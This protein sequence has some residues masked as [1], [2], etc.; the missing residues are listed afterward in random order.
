MLIEWSFFIGVTAVKLFSISFCNC[1]KLLS[2][3]AWLSSKLSSSSSKAR[4]IQHAIADRSL[5]SSNH[6]FNAFL[7]FIRLTQSRFGWQEVMD[8]LSQTEVYQSF[9]LTE[10][11]VEL[12][13]H[14][15]VC[16]LQEIIIR[17]NPADV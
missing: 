5:R 10:T 7:C 4:Y 6:S 14:W 1:C 8:L 13:S 12:I 16:F 2:V 9:G 15:V 3:A 11:D 17:H